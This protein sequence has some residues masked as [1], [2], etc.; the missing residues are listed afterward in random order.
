MMFIWSLDYVSIPTT[1]L[2]MTGKLIIGSVT[3]DMDGLSNVTIVDLTPNMYQLRL[4][5]VTGRI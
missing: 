1:A 2:I 4:G 5:F 3:W